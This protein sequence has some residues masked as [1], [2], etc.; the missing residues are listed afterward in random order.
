VKERNVVIEERNKARARVRELEQ[1]NAVQREN[2]DEAMR[3][4]R[5]APRRSANVR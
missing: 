2:V 4:R 1:Q 3:I 5:P